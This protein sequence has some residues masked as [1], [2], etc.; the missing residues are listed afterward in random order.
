MLSIIIPFVSLYTNSVTDVNYVD[1]IVAILFAIIVFFEFIHTPSGTA[2]CVSGRFKA[3]RNI[4]IT[5]LIVLVPS[6]IIGSLIFKL[7]GIMIA[8][9]I[10]SILLSFMEII[11]AHKKV[12]NA[13]LKTIVKM[14][15]F[16]LILI[17]AESLIWNCF[18]IS[19]T[20]Y[21]QFF[22]Y[23]IVIF[24]INSSIIIILNK[25]VFNEYFIELLNMVKNIII[26]FKNKEVK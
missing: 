26:N 19:F 21:F 1:P 12:F 20:N 9:A 8:L 18:N 5:A 3:A 11:Y 23:G 4:Q 6:L 15:L 16:N 10:T 13:N 22:V 14:A 24:L 17:I 25:I 2:I 7:Y